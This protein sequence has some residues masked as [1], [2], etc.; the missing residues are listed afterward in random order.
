MTESP[1]TVVRRC[2]PTT[3]DHISTLRSLSGQPTTVDVLCQTGVSELKTGAVARPWMTF[4]FQPQA[5]HGRTTYEAPLSIPQSFLELRMIFEVL[6]PPQRT[7]AWRLKTVDSQ[8]QTVHGRTTYEDPRRRLRGIRT[9][10]AVQFPR[11]T[12]DQMS[13]LGSISRQ[14]TTSWVHRHASEPKTCVVLRTDPLTTYDFQPQTAHGQKIGVPPVQLTTFSARRMP[15]T[16][17]EVHQLRQKTSSVSWMPSPCPA[18]RR[19][20]PGGSVGAPTCDRRPAARPRHPR[21]TSS[22]ARRRCSEVKSGLSLTRGRTSRRR[23]ASRC[24]CCCCCCSR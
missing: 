9:I 18:G 22:S 13:L 7:G 4:E 21:S 12:Y 3:R 17:G 20:K 10:S 11:T 8:P 5:V 1:T 14:P 24:C 19:R 15:T 23:V 2:Q 16:T 6:A